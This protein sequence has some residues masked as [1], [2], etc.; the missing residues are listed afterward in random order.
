MADG[1]DLDDANGVDI[2]IYPLGE[3]D[4]SDED[5]GGEDFEMHNLSKRQLLA[6][7]EVKI[8]SQ[9]NDFEQQCSK[10]EIKTNRLVTQ[11]KI[12]MQICQME[13]IR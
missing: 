8:H 2:V 12:L 10:S 4:D 11:S 1:T 3:G 13:L 6:A 7:V 5:S 9:S